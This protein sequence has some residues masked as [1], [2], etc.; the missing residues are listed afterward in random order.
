MKKPIKKILSKSKSKPKNR[1]AKI[2][3]FPSKLSKY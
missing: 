3:R 2:F 1:K